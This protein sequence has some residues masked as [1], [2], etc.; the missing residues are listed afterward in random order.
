MLFLIY[1]SDLCLAAGVVKGVTVSLTPPDMTKCTMLERIFEYPSEQ[2]SSD[3]LVLA[4]LLAQDEKK[5]YRVIET[6]YAN[7]TYKY[8]ND[9]NGNFVFSQVLDVTNKKEIPDEQTQWLFKVEDGTKLV[10][11]P[12][13]IYR[14]SYG[15]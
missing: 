11:L 10:L 3:F 9:I 12:P 7:S 5:N 13:T 4:M 2:V 6:E 14:C 1:F 15:T 8:A